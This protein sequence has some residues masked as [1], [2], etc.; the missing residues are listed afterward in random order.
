MTEAASSIT[1][2]TLA[3]TEFPGRQG[4]QLAG[5]PPEGI[6]IAIETGAALRSRSGEPCI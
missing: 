5:S 2:A 4:A 6:Q 1:T 3:E